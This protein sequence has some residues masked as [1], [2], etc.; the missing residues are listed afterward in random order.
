MCGKQDATYRLRVGEYRVFY[1]VGEGVVTV[2]AVFHKRDTVRFC[3][4]EGP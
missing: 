2:V 4:E 1:D 3:R